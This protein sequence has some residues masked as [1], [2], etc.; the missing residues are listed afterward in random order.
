MAAVEAA[1]SARAA[2]A[3]GW[4]FGTLAWACGMHWFLSPLVKFMDVPVWVG[5]WLWLAVCAWHGLMAG[6]W[7]LLGRALAG[8]GASRAGRL[9]LAAAPAWVLVEAFFPALF[10]VALADSQLAHL[11]AVQSVELFGRSGLSW[12]IMGANAGLWLACRRPR[13][14]APLLTALALALLNEAYGLLRIGQVDDLAARA[15]ASGRLLRAGVVQ[16]VWPIGWVRR[17]DP[18]VARK[19]AHHR[20]LG[21]PLAAA[22]AEL[23][24][25]P[26]Y[27]YGRVIDYERPGGAP[28]GFRIDGRPARETLRR[29]LPGRVPVLLSTMG[30]AEG[31]R[32]NAAFLAGPDREVAGLF[33]K[34]RLFPFGEYAP[35]GDVFPFLYRINPRIARL[36]AGGAPRA[37]PGP[38]GSRLGV[39]VCY[40]DIFPD[41]ARDLARAGADLL[42]NVTN[43]IWFDAGRAPEQHMRYGALRA[44]ETRRAML[45]AANTGV[46]AYV[47][48][49]GR[50][51]KRIGEERRGSFLAA[52]PLLD[53]LTPY[54]RLGELARALAAALLLAQALALRRRG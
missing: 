44:V 38:A 30:A 10:P 28:S 3:R 46:S 52:V 31:R 24:V 21:A 42:V 48:P 26:E 20:E 29:D 41:L 49:V 27:A 1:P 7:A 11:P 47:D 53:G 8:R 34:R 33:E 13:R 51:V 22:G 14:W 15:M 54:A 35:L 39:L 16:G 5:A 50:V 45:K 32:Y 40:E 4:G 9:A 37:L 18:G 17:G 19:I 36:S 12:L 25:W 2:F 6:L 23:L 43:D